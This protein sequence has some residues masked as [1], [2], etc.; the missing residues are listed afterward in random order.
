MRKSEEPVATLIAGPKCVE[1]LTEA[2]SRAIAEN[3]LR[4]VDWPQEPAPDVL[5]RFN[6]CSRPRR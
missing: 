2:P 5:A 4:L 6:A 1:E 3:A